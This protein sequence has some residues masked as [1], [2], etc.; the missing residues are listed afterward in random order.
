MANTSIGPTLA[1]T[2]SGLPT[3][4]RRAVTKRAAELIAEEMTLR[5]LR[6]SL[7]LTQVNVARTLNKGQHE[8]SRIEQRGDMLISTLS[9]FVHAMGGEL[10]LICR[11]KKRPPIRIM[12]LTAVTPPRRRGKQDRQKGRRTA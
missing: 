5:E 6:R 3:A 12:P 2:I 9:S 11:F 8:I 1:E 10:E 4:Q 7:A